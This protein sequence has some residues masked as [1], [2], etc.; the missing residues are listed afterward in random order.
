MTISEAPDKKPEIYWRNDQDWLTLNY[1]FYFLSLQEIEE[2]YAGDIV[3]FFGMDCASGDTFVT[4][5]H[6]NLSMVRQSYPHFV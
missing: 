3:A 6:M 1:F 4:K 2:A 5:G